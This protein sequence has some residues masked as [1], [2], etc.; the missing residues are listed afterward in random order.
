MWLWDVHHPRATPPLLHGL[1]A[2][3]QASPSR[4]AV[5]RCR[6]S[7]MHHYS[8]TSEACLGHS[9]FVT[10]CRRDSRSNYE[11]FN[12]NNFN[13]RYWSW[14]YRG[15]WNAWETSPEAARTLRTARATS[16]RSP[17]KARER[18]DSGQVPLGRAE[19]VRTSNFKLLPEAW[20]RR[21]RLGQVCAHRPTSFGSQRRKKNFFEG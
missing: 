12:C 9:N 17:R 15:C 3:A 11:Q 5:K 14:N 21:A 18:S 13:I 6:G 20:D 7:S 1:R 8:G 19:G 4:K 16:G 2:G 10:A